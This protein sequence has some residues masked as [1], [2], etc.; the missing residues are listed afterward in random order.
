MKIHIPNSTFLGNID[1]FLHSIINLPNDR[2]DLTANKKWISI[3]PVVLAMIGAIGLE[4]GKESVFC[5]KLEATSKSYLERMKLFEILGISSDIIY[6]K[7]EPSDR[8]IPLTQ[9]KNSNALEQFL[10]DMVPLLHLTPDQ[11]EPIKYIISELTRNVFE[12]AKAK[13]GAV[14]CAQYYK[15][16]NTVR[17][18]IVDKGVGI[19]QTINKA[20][21]DINSDLEAIKLALTSG[22]TGTS[23][24]EGGTEFNAGA[25]LFFIKSI[26]KINRD[27]FM[28]YSGNTMYKL[29]KRPSEA[30]TIRL[31][32]NPFKDKH[33]KA[34]DYPVWHGTVIGIDISLDHNKKFSELLDLINPTYFKSIIERKKQKHKKPRFI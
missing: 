10:S 5:E 28:L 17:L 18:G 13:N 25:G 12:H 14:V 21:P 19:K 23:L 8:F 20:Y 6:N 33:S 27:F 11:A 30:K 4:I 31:Y 32:A 15:K 29:L 9:I 7:H 2:L 16:S 3:H 1:P 34:D 22:I 26:A 24:Q